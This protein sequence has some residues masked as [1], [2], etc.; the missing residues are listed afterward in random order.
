MGGGGPANCRFP[1]YRACVQ[2]MLRLSMHRQ[3]SKATGTAAA[4]RGRS[5]GLL[6]VSVHHLGAPLSITGTGLDRRVT[7]QL[8][9]IIPTIHPPRTTMPCAWKQHL[10]GSSQNTIPVTTLY[11]RTAWCVYSTVAGYSMLLYG[12]IQYSTLGG[13]STLLYSS[14]HRTAPS[15]CMAILMHVPSYAIPVLVFRS[16]NTPSIQQYCCVQTFTSLTAGRR[17]WARYPGA[18]CKL[19]AQ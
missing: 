15:I 6:S 5:E 10:P 12:G 11:V 9:G 14:A 16:S 19:C 18:N 13:Y 7:P 2:G 3:P 4:R 8:V 1:T 17:A